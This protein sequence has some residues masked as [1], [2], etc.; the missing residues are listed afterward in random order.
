MALGV[1]LAVAVS[2]AVGS[3]L[4]LGDA[5]GVA[6]GVGDGGVAVPV[7]VSLGVAT[8]TLRSPEL[9]HASTLSDESKSTL[10]RPKYQTLI[11]GNMLRGVPW[12]LMT[13][14]L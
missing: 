10:L 12:S 6:V 1:G 13:S 11:D 14:F 9:S 5:V 3:R 4:G 2:V 8:E 7:A